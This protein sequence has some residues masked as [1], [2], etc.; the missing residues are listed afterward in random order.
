MPNINNLGILQKLDYLTNQINQLWGNFN[1]FQ[2]NPVVT[3][4]TAKLSSGTVTVSSSVVKTGDII[5]I[6]QYSPS[7]TPLSSYAVSTITSGTS[8]VIKAYNITT[9][10]VNT[11]DNSTVGYLISHK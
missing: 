5:F 6:T 1:V 7:G 8:F 3:V 11:S 2:T 4:G 10:A 9:G